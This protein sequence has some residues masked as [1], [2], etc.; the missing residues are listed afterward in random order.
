MVC[1]HP[2][3]AYQRKGK[4]PATGNGYKPIFRLPPDYEIDGPDETICDTVTYRS[5]IHMSGETNPAYEKIQLPCGQCIGCRLAYAAQWACRCLHESRLYDNNCFLTLT[6]DDEHIDPSMSLNKTDFKDFIKRFRR[7]LEYY[8]LGDKIRYFQCGE[9]G[10]K[11]QRPHHHAII[12]NFDFPD[13]YLWTQSSS[14]ARLYRSPMLEEL[15]PFGFSS[16]GNVTFE[17]CGYVARYVTKKIKGKGADEFYG[18]RLP[19][20]LTMS[21][22][23]GIGLEWLRKYVRDIYPNDF[24]VMPGGRLFK[25]PRYYDQMYN[26]LQAYAQLELLRGTS[27]ID[28]IKQERKNRMLEQKAKEYD[29]EQ[30]EIER[31][32]VKEKVKLYKIQSLQRNLE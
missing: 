13:K 7:R 31:L 22:K 18:D 4:N 1:Y 15:W 12:F 19:P 24:V 5:K 2:L 17:T 10:T 9:Y 14:G 25:P 30:E 28:D 11:Y 6:Y 8:H 21:R 26:Y 32:L 3:T 23:P 16:I 29:T 20:Y 27:S